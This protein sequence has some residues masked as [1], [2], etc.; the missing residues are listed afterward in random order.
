MALLVVRCRVQGVSKLLNGFARLGHSP[1]VAFH[2]LVVDYC[3]RQ[4]D[5][6]AFQPVTICMLLNGLTKLD[7]R[8][9]VRPPRLCFERP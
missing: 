2:D 1:G 4:Q 3:M 6:S 7:Y 8:P 9:P 5:M